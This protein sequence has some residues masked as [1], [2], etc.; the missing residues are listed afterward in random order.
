M[1]FVLC[2]SIQDTMFISIVFFVPS[3]ILVYCHEMNIFEC[4]CVCV[5]AVQSKSRYQISLKTVHI[6]RNV[7]STFFFGEG[8]VVEPTLLRIE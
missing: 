1:C 8:V 4:V 2:G 5:Y 6:F 7:R 3:P